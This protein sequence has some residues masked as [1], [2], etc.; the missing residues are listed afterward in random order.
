ME[1][2]AYRGAGTLT[3]GTVLFL[4]GLVTR[5]VEGSSLTTGTVLLTAGL[6]FIVFLVR[7]GLTLL[8]DRGFKAGA[9]S[10]SRVVLR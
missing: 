8:A 4:H 7:I 9:A 6:P 10:S 3:F 5:R 1:G 2:G